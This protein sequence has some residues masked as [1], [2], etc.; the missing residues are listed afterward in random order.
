MHFLG[1]RQGGALGSLVSPETRV[2]RTSPYGQDEKAQRTG[3]AVGTWPPDS[4][5][6]QPPSGR[7]RPGPAG[8]RMSPGGPHTWAS[9]TQARWGA[10]R[11]EGGVERSPGVG[12]PRERRQ[13]GPGSPGRKGIRRRGGLSGGGVRE[14]PRLL[15]LGVHAA[16][17]GLRSHQARLAPSA[18]P[19]PSGR[20]P[21]PDGSSCSVSGTPLLHE[22]CLGQEAAG[23]PVPSL[24]GQAGCGP[25]GW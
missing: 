14:K 4:V 19:R 24:S 21:Q 1:R 16:E 25:W 10:A 3:E 8:V 5:E 18:T 15:G 12:L 22:H 9:R 7:L 20:L 17:A 11:V 6:Q 23:P 2:A 13:W